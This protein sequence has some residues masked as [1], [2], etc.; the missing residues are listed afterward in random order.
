MRVPSPFDDKSLKLLVEKF[1]YKRSVNFYDSGKTHPPVE[2]IWQNVFK[3]GG[4]FNAICGTQKAGKSRL[5]LWWIVSILGG[6]NIFR[7]RCDL[8]PKRIM[9]IAAEEGEDTVQYRLTRYCELLGVDP[10]LIEDRVVIV[11]GQQMALHKQANRTMLLAQIF[12]LD[13][14]IVLIDPFFNIHASDENGGPEFGAMITEF[15]DWTSN[16]KFDIILIHH[17]MKN[18]EYFDPNN[19]ATWMRGSSALPGIIDDALFV[20]RTGQIGAN[21]GSMIL[22][23][24]NGRSAS[25][26]RVWRLRDK[27]RENPDKPVESDLGW[28]WTNEG[29]EIS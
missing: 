15:S 3:G 14:D 10:K 13:I 12:A 11:Q 17:S 29:S 16:Y 22:L 7:R 4:K 26:G 24:R 1:Q 23:Y 21:G 18:L 6:L 27:G 28:E 19:M 8:P 2:W 25:D 20:S 5:A 9:I